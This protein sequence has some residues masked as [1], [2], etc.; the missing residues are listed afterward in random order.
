MYR[1]INIY[2]IYKYEYICMYGLYNNIIYVIQYYFTLHLQSVMVRF[3]TSCM[4]TTHPCSCL[5]HTGPP[6]YISTE[7]SPKCNGQQS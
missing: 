6:S 1:I 3:P 5:E 4:V 2:Y 7:E